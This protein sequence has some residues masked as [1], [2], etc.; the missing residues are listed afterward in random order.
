[1]KIDGRNRIFPV[2]HIELTL[3]KFLSEANGIRCIKQIKPQTIRCM[4]E[5]PVFKLCV[6]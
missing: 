1:M 4:H 3:Q 5:K 2:W 6:G